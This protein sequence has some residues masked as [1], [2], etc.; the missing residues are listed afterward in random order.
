[1]KIKSFL[2]I[3]FFINGCC[4]KPLYQGRQSQSKVIIKISTN[5][6]TKYRL[7]QELNKY[8]HLIPNK[9]TIFVDLKIIENFEYLVRLPNIQIGRT[10]G[11]LKIE[12]IISK[13]NRKPFYKHSFERMS[14]YTPD[15]K[16]EFGNIMAEQSIE[17][18]STESIAKEI[19]DEIAI[20]CET[21]GA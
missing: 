16:E 11:C 3:L 15:I 2:F 7:Q 1:M 17:N 21:N 9:N 18:T 13:L 14:S 20:A 12:M 8:I 10:L 5:S 19:I 4:F 6:Y